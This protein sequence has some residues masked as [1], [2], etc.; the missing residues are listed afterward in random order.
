MS[1]FKKVFERERDKEIALVIEA[2][3]IGIIS[4]LIIVL[5]RLCIKY[6][7]S[8][9]NYM[10]ALGKGNFIYVLLGFT[11]ILGLAFLVKKMLDKEPFISGSGIPQLEGE[12]VGHLESKWYRV[13]FYKF[14]GGITALLGGLSL[15]REGPSIQLGAMVGKGVSKVFKCDKTET[16]YLLTCGASAGLAAAFHAPMAS[17]MFALEEVHK[18]FAPRLIAA[19]M[20]SA[21]VS[22]FVLS[23]ILGISPVFSFIISNRVPRKYYYI[24][25]FLGI[26][27]GFAGVLYNSVL[28]KLQVFMQKKVKSNYFRIL[29]PFIIAFVLAYTYPIVL[30]SG[31]RIV[32]I[33]DS[34]NYTVMALFVMLV[35]K[36]LFS[37]VSYDSGAPGG[38][39]FPLLVLAALIGSIVYKI[40]V[41]GLGVEDLYLNNFIIF[42]MAGLF[43]SIVRAPVTGII[44]VFEMTGELQSLLAISLVTMISYIVAELCKSLPVYDS[45]LKNLINNNLADKQLRKH[46]EEK[47]VLEFSVY[48]RSKVDGKLVKDITWPDDSLLVTIMTECAEIIPN[49]NTRI[50]TGDVLVMMCNVESQ[51]ECYERMLTLTR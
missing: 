24:L 36:F 14:V 8:I 9:L 11:M 15:G 43:A 7:T 31:D 33:L 39:F 1:S 27:L 51:S 30:G 28:T 37:V 12:L 45:L 10:I 21:I 19:V 46:S 6:A 4:S 32:D 25:V 44:L 23:G 22:D 47:M 49:G 38:I 41:M 13:I 20:V 2:L 16:R 35:I 17:V 29:I 18:K 48:D 26:I 50:K 3:V 34:S 42:A 40:A 5:Y